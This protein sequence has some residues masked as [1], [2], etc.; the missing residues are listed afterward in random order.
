MTPLDTALRNA[1]LLSWWGAC[2][3]AFKVS[4]E[5]A[6]AAHLGCHVSEVGDRDTF[7]QDADVLNWLAITYPHTIEAYV[8]DQL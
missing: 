7:S 8:N 3:A 1:T 6:Y 4:V 2:D 5:Y